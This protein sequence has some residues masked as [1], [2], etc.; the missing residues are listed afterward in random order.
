MSKEMTREQLEEALAISEA[1]DLAWQGAA[2][3]LGNECGFLLYDSEGAGLGYAACRRCKSR[4]DWKTHPHADWCAVGRMEA[5]ILSYKGKDPFVA[6]CKGSKVYHKCAVEALT[7]ISE[8][9]GFP[10]KF[11]WPACY[12]VSRGLNSLD[13]WS[14]AHLSDVVTKLRPCR[15]CYKE[16]NNE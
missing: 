8:A 11:G 13:R 9:I 10:F 15:R 3:A 12:H 1:R 7:E 6:V 16:T 14:N 2:R 5:M 4:G